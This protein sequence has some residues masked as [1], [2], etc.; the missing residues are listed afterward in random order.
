[1]YESLRTV[2]AVQVAFLYCAGVE[3]NAYTLEQWIQL[4]QKA[5]NFLNGYEIWTKPPIE[6]PPASDAASLKEN[7]AQDVRL[8]VAPADIKEILSDGGLIE[9]DHDRWVQIHKFFIKINSAVDAD[10]ILSCGMTECV[11]DSVHPMWQ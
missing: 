3:L 9:W 1:M 5:A 8:Y 6:K 4:G 11:R 10:L 2:A 7:G